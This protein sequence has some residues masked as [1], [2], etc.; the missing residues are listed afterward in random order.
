[1]SPG[2]YENTFIR[3]GDSKTRRGLAQDKQQ[4]SLGWAALA[5]WEVKE[6]GALGRG[7]GGQPGTSCQLT[8]ALEFRRLVPLGKEVWGEEGQ[9]SGAG[10]SP[11]GE[12][13]PWVLCLEAFIPFLQV[14]ILGEVSGVGFSRICISSPGVPSQ[15]HGL[16]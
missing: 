13:M 9:G 14:G 12:C 15:G 7:S 2:D 3:G 5:H 6:E 11:K 1:M 8:I 16:H 10:R 4:E